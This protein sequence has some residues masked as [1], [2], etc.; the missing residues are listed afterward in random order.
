MHGA[1]HALSVVHMIG[2]TAI[3]IHIVF[4]CEHLCDN[5]AGPISHEILN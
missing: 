1:L 5:G 2:A 4:C 3:L